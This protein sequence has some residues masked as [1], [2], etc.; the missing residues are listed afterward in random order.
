[1]VLSQ[2]PRTVSGDG[3]RIRIRISLLSEGQVAFSVRPVGRSGLIVRLSS[4]GDL[5]RRLGV[6]SRDFRGPFFGLR[7]SF[8]C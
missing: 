7:L 1:M 5:S 8:P 6:R 2:I 4:V 3:I